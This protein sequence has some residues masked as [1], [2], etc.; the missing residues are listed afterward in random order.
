MKAPTALLVTALVVES[1]CRPR[2]SVQPEPK[3][4]DVTPEPGAAAQVQPKAVEAAPIGVATKR[5]DGMIVLLLY[6]D[7]ASGI[8]GETVFRYSPG[9]PEYSRISAHVG[10]LDPGQTVLVRPWP[11]EK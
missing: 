10:P 5:A 6:A 11:E 7:S 2:P 3:T 4:G 1:A 9:H 8:R